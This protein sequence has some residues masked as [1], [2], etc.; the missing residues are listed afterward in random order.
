MTAALAPE[1]LATYAGNVVRA[2]GASDAFD[3]PAD[4]RARAKIRV[5]VREA[6]VEARP[7]P[8]GPS[9]AEALTDL[10]EDARRGWVD[11]Q[12][13]ARRLAELAALFEQAAFRRTKRSA[14]ARLFAELVVLFE[15][16]P[17]TGL[18]PTARTDEP[19]DGEAH[20]KLVRRRLSGKARTR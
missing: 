6:L 11:R 1:V 15:L 17:A 13:A 5:R 8:G 10:L 4:A 18:E 19:L 20:L 9:L 16:E 14:R 3:A 7:H 2:F 12:G